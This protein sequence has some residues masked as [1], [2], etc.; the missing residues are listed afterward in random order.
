[1]FRVDAAT[2]VVR[3]RVLLPGFCTALGEDGD[4]VRLS[5]A[6]A[7]GADAWAR[8]YRIGPDG[9]DV[10]FFLPASFITARM[11]RNDAENV[12]TGLLEADPE[13][14]QRQPGDDDWR[15]RPE[16]RPYLEAAIAELAVLA[17]RDPTNPWYHYWRGEYFEDLEQPEDATAAFSVL[18]LDP[19]YD[20]E[21]LPMVLRFDAD[22]NAVR[23]G[24][25]I[26]IGGN[27]RYVSVCRKHFRDKLYR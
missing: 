6:S 27:D 2:G 20:F 17:K 26:E 1:M 12:L 9:H 22:G 19:A 8:S 24:S 16:L 4:G 3:A 10:P 13:A 14:P 23:E 15:R 7:S 5:V 21:L 11:S 25:Q 18:G